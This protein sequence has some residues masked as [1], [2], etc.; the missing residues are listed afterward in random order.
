MERSILIELYNCGYC[1]TLEEISEYI[2][3]HLFNTFC[4]H[5]KTKYNIDSK[6]EF[7]KCSWQPGW[8][9]KFKKSGKSLCT[10]YPRHMYFTV[11]VVIGRREKEQV[12][13]LLSNC[14]PE[15]QSIYSQTK[16]GNGQKWLMIDLEDRDTLYEDVLRLIDIRRTK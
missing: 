6:I 3:N 5:I 16:E 13:V 9:I 14:S 1:P 10:I 15:L 8:N 12:E 7:S 4:L 2:R 11:L